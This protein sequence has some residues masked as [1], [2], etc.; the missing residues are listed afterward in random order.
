[1]IIDKYLISLYG[2]NA[3]KDIYNNLECRVPFWKI[4][5]YSL[6]QYNYSSYSLK[7][8]LLAKTIMVT[9]LQ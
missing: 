8:R 6:K 5:N 4:T 2:N 1:M 3:T 7:T 9:E